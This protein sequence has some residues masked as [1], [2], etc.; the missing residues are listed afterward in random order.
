MPVVGHIPSSHCFSTHVETFVCKY[1]RTFGNMTNSYM[2]HPR[3]WIFGFLIRKIPNLFIVALS[4]FAWKFNVKEFYQQ[5]K[6]NQITME[7]LLLFTSFC[8]K[9]AILKKKTTIANKE[10]KMWNQP[11]IGIVVLLAIFSRGASDSGQSNLY[12][13]CLFLNF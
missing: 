5:K 1:A 12:N 6:A 8:I 3:N 10:R 13:F 11:G 7:N 4:P 2:S 9:D